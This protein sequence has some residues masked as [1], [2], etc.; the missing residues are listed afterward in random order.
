MGKDNYTRSK[1]ISDLDLYLA[2]EGTHRNLD[3]ILGARPVFNSTGLVEGYYFAVWAPNAKCVSVVGEFND[4]TAGENPMERIEGTGFWEAYVENAKTF[5][6]YK[7]CILTQNNDILYKA[8]PMAKYAEL[9]PLTASKTYTDSYRWHDFQWRIKHSKKHDKNQ[10]MA[11]YEM[12]MGSWMRGENNAILSYRQVADALVKYLKENRYTHIEIMPIAE[13]PFDGSWGYQVTGYFAPTSRYGT[14]EDFKYFVDTMHKHSIGVILDWVP[15]H[16][17]KDEHGLACFDGTPIYEGQSD[18]AHSEWGTLK[19]DFSSPMVRQFL[20]SN[21][22]Y[23]FKEFHIDGLRADAISSMVYLDYGKSE[24]QWTPN[25]YGGKENLE[26]VDFLKELNNEVSKYFPGAITVAE[27]SGNFPLVT[28]P[29]EEGGLG[30][31]YK[32]NMGWMNDTLEY[33]QKDPL[34]RKGIHNYMTFSMMYAYNESYILPISHDECVHGKKSLLDKMSGTY[35]EKFA[36]EKAYL[37]YMFTHPGKKLLFMGC[38]I[39][40]FI[41]WRYYEQ[42]EW[43]LLQY[44]THRGLYMFCKAL[45]AMYNDH[46]AFWQRDDNWAGFGWLNADDAD[47]SVYSMARYSDDETIIAV[48][49]MTPVERFDYW[50][51]APIEGTYKLILNSD[52][53]VYGGQGTMVNSEL[54]TDTDETVKNRIRLTLPPLS[55]LFYKLEK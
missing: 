44:E 25:I 28:H 40:Q 32:W 21:A 30:F 54:V 5:Q 15:G 46:S 34:F 3:E 23:W 50:L 55:V 43:K 42:I 11:I 51:T 22:L 37:G 16:F 18:D 27:E 10:P 53:R 45:L 47:H 52:D 4:W 31:T 9:R 35:Y 19:F 49:N 33:V 13:H 41:E 26:A 24:G 8:D 12:H 39:G 48:V 38:E 6:M 14:P 17:P 36:T 7:Y 29:V 2:C 1:M 20:I